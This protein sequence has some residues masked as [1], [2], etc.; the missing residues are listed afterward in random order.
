[1]EN[2]LFTPMV[3]HGMMKHQYIEIETLFTF[4]NRE[5]SDG[6]SQSVFQR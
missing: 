6:T 3:E 1:M 5:K 2:I 4:F